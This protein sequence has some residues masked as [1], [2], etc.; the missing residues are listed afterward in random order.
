MI[1]LWTALIKGIEWGKNYSFVHLFSNSLLST[2][3]I[4]ANVHSHEQ[5]K[6]LALVELS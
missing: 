3:Y 6:I 4:L 1:Y 2:F 5:S